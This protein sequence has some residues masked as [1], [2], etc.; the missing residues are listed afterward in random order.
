M[1]GEG[2]FER[3][4]FPGF[5]GQSLGFEVLAGGEALEGP[6]FIRLQQVP[7]EGAVLV[8]FG[9]GRGTNAPLEKTLGKF[10][11]RHYLYI[12]LGY[13]GDQRWPGGDAIKMFL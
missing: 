9:S 13:R 11:I 6:G 4:P 7:R 10:V 8:K 12:D 5:L 3:F 2:G 1:V